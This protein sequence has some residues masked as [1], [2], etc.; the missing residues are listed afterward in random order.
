M[1]A[2]RARGFAL[3]VFG[4][5]WSSSVA[6]LKIAQAL[7]VEAADMSSEMRVRRWL[8]NRGVVVRAVWA[9][10]L[11]S[12]LASQGGKTVT[13]VLDPTPQNGR[14]AILQLGLVCRRRVLPTAWR[15]VAQQTPWPQR[16]LA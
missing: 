5:V 4:L 13:L 14:F 12:L 10:L 3:I 9:A 8:K 11:P 7:P 1:R 6:L 16:Q 2:T 15:V